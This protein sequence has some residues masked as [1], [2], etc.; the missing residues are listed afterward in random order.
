MKKSLT[1]VMLLKWT[2]LCTDDSFICFSV[3]TTDIPTCSL[4]IFKYYNLYI[5][6]DV[7]CN[8][9][10]V[11]VLMKHQWEEKEEAGHREERERGCCQTYNF[12][13]T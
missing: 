8:R 11:G 10:Y 13:S 5:F 6:L 4:Q 3:W 12:A 9:A 7:S 1:M 2:T